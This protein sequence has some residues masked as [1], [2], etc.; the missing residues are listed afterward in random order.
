MKIER[1]E[2][3]KKLI[4]IGL[5]CLMVGFFNL[6]GADAQG[7][8][9]EPLQDRTRFWHLALV[10]KD[11]EKMHDFY[12]RVLGLKNVTDL[13]FAD[14]ETVLPQEPYKALLGLDD[15]MGMEK[16]KVKIRHY[17]DPEHAQF[18]ELMYYPDHPAQQVDREM[19][20]PLGLNHLGLRVAD[21]DSVLETIRSEKIGAIIGGP[22]ILTEFNSSRFVLLKDPEGNL[23]EL[24]ELAK[25]E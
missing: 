6:R 21:M 5:F 11:M 16:T 7:Q 10:V 24:Y 9:V 14:G 2:I 12:T 25:Q 13:A 15:L 20:K 8:A 1:F 4:F 22:V 17:T 18:L 3:Q 23:V 19:Y